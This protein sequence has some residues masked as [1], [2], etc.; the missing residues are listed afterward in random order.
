MIELLVVKEAC[1]VFCRTCGQLRLWAK[2]GQPKVCQHC[3]SAEIVTGAVNGAELPEL[4]RVWKQER[5]KADR[6]DVQVQIREGS[7]WVW[8]TAH[9]GVTKDE[10][11]A[12]AA[13]ALDHRESPRVMHAGTELWARAFELRLGG[14]SFL[15][16]VYHNEIEVDRARKGL[17]KHE[18]V[19]RELWRTKA[20]AERDRAHFEWQMGRGSHPDEPSEAERQG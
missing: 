17:E 16:G 19:V 20:E 7:E 12:L 14:G 6:Y 1:E 8:A 13:H 2:G 10:A 5:A 4:Q 18:L 3:G 15:E 11:I 9:G